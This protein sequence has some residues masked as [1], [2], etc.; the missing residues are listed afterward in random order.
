MSVKYLQE[1]SLNHLPGKPVPTLDSPFSKEIFPNIQPKPPLMQLEAIASRPVT[2]YLG[3]ETNTSLTTT[4]FQ[5][6]VESDKVSPSLLFSTA[7]DTSSS[8]PAKPRLSC[9]GQGRTL[10][11]HT[12][13][14]SSGSPPARRAELY[15]GIHPP[16]RKRIHMMPWERP[17]KLS[18]SSSE[19]GRYGPG[20]T[21]T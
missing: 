18:E 14:S 21:S 12:D 10:Q 1:W 20:T 2:V 16:R 17:H 19:L 3:E 5:V 7:E 13:L 4:S 15:P 9:H 6:V 8:S 11:P